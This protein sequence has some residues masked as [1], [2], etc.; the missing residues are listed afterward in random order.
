MTEGVKMSRRVLGYCEYHEQE[1]D[2]VEFE[3][4]GCWNCHYFQR[5]EDFPYMDVGEAARELS[6]SPSTIRRWL[7][8]GKLKGRL[9]VRGRRVYQLGSPRK[10]FVERVSVEEL[11]QRRL[12]SP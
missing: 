11:K 9:F 3:W 6:V 10:W 5:G 7:R 1:V 8:G 4:K 12:K 2:E